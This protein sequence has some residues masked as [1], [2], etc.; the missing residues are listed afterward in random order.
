MNIRW[1]GS[2]G[3][4]IL[5][6][7]FYCLTVGTT[8]EVPCPTKMIDLSY[9]IGSTESGISIRFTNA[10]ISYR[11]EENFKGTLEEAKKLCEEHLYTVLEETCWQLKQLVHRPI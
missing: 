5:D 7:G 8:E 4:N 3:T 10:L 11:L 9:T 1:N 2:D 6:E